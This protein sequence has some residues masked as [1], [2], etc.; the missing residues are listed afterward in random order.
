MEVH[1]TASDKEKFIVRFSDSASGVNFTVGLTMPVVAK[2]Q[3][4]T[5][6]LLSTI[7][8][9]ADEI[10]L[11]HDATKPLMPEYMFTAENTAPTLEATIEQIR[12]N[13]I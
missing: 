11:S 4:Q 1:V 12:T 2:W 6:Q 5:N 8:V 9:L 7:T 3:M 13:P 10:L